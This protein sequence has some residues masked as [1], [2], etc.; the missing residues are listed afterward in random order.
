M[1]WPASVRS[2]IASNYCCRG[3]L[4]LPPNFSPSARPA[5][6]RSTKSITANRRTKFCQ[7]RI[8]SANRPVPGSTVT[9]PA[10]DEMWTGAVTSSLRNCSPANIRRCA[11]ELFANIGNYFRKAP[12]MA[13]GLLKSARGGP[14]F[15]RARIG[16]HFDRPRPSYSRGFRR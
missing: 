12:V 6:L 9:L 8:I 15:S 1:P 3:S 11:T 10:R 14:H 7:S 4:E 2:S 13:L 16:M 5:L